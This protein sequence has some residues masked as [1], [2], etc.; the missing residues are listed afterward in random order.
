MHLVCILSA[1]C[2]QWGKRKSFK[3]TGLFCSVC[4]GVQLSS[5]PA[6]QL[7]AGGTPVSRCP[8]HRSVRAE[9]PHTAPTSG[10][11]HRIAVQ[12]KGGLVASVGCT[13]LAREQRELRS[14]MGG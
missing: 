9:L 8:P 13:K 5:Y 10:I 3:K 14:T 1:L 2:T 4:S 7:V 12:G 6:I 11:T